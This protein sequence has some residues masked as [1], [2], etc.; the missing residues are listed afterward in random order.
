MNELE[1]RVALVTGST[2]GIG[3][4]IAE[5]LVTEGALVAV[6]GTREAAA[7]DAAKE[8]GASIGVGADVSDPAAV[9]TMVGR[10]TDELG[11]IEV[12]VNNAG[13][14]SQLSFLDSDIELWDKTLRVNLLGPVHVLRA[15][16]PA[17]VA[18]G[19][20]R[21]LNVTSAAAVGP[22]PGFPVYAASKGGLLA[23]S[24]TMAA[25]LKGTGITVNALAPLAVTDMLRQM[26][27]QAVNALIDR[28][29]PTVE[30][31]GEEAYVL[32]ADGAA[33]G[34]HVVMSFS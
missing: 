10:I 25:E 14:S 34:K 5:R 18:A 8:I 4:A 7:A 6:H 32:L 28:G 31:C 1:G 27:E 13:F 16:V 24:L 26:P 22:T 30:Q 2:R 23:L 33:T 15:T 29:M 11:P 20:G 19:W 17:M 21:V 12:L 3:K 9:G